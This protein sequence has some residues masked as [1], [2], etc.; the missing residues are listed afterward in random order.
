MAGEKV[1]ESMQVWT[2]SVGAS[3]EEDQNV[4]V[5]GGNNNRA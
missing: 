3:I 1:Y 5:N 2:E 4:Q